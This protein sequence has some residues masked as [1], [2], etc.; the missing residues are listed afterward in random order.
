ML[1]SKDSQSI[2]NMLGG[3]KELPHVPSYVMKIE[4]VIEDEN[5]TSSDLAKVIKQA[6]IFAAKILNSVNS[7]AHAKSQKIESLE[8]AISYI[9]RDYIKDY[10]LIA[11]LNTF[12]FETKKFDP[13]VFWE[14][15]FL[16]GV[17]TEF[18]GEKVNTKEEKGKLYV[19]GA[20]AN[21]GK[22]V[23]AMIAPAE[24]D[25]LYDMINEPDSLATWEKGE[26]LLA[27]PK[28]TLLGEIG[29]VFWGVPDYILKGIMHH[30]IT[31]ENIKNHDD[32]TL[33]VSLANQLSHWLLMQPHM[34]DEAQVEALLSHFNLQKKDGEEIVESILYDQKALLI[35]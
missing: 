9:G 17:L 16:T 3:L 33:M 32:L 28:H 8:H 10:I 14:Q 15:S 29:S 12:K 4:K 1:L 6:P 19:S 26:R 2:F 23:Q 35:V 20:L 21:I 22:I 25:K 7:S 30:H 13:K 34:S 24:T 5:A 11:V 27:I 31:P 18:I